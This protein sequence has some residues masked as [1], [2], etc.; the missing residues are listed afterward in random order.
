MSK[1]QDASQLDEFD[2][3]ELVT[4]HHRDGK[5]AVPVPAVVVRREPGCVII[6]CRIENKIE[7]LRVDPEELVAR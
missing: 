3:S 7:E 4:W 6:R 1:M 5:Y 2:E